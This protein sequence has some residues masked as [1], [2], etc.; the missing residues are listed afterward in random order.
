MSYNQF[1]FYDSKFQQLSLGTMNP[2]DRNNRNLNPFLVKE[3]PN[4]EENFL[5]NQAQNLIGPSK[6]IESGLNLQES[7]PWDSN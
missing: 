1:L 6:K 4:V 3:N 2:E 7:K 5:N